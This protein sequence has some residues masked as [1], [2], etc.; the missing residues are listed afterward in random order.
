MGG[1]KD[2]TASRVFSLHAVDLG[3]T[4]HPEPTRSNPCGSAPPPPRIPTLGK[5][6]GYSLHWKNGGT[7]GFAFIA[8]IGQP[9]VINKHYCRS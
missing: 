6:E 1:P 2:S 9:C 8:V 3:L 5:L 7:S 4:Q